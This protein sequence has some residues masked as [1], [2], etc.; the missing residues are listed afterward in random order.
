[1]GKTIKVEK[2]DG[3]TKT[4]VGTF[5]PETKTIKTDSGKL[6]Y[7]GANDTVEVEPCWVVTATFGAESTELRRVSRLCRRTFALNPILVPGWCL[8]KLCGPT[9]AQW[10][11]S[12]G[13]GGRICKR[14]LATP[15]VQ[16]TVRGKMK[17][18]APKVYLVFLTFVGFILIILFCLWRS[19]SG[20]RYL[21]G[22]WAR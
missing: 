8:Y 17:A 12:S 20:P 22:P 9:L 21:S 1:M 19:M 5:D 4:Y 2:P 11:R 7:P 13:T 15:I 6:V 16:A 10:A 18:L 14:F 3:R